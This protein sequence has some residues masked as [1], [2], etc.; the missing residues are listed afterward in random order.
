MMEVTESEE[1]ELKDLFALKSN[2]CSNFQRKFL[3][4]VL[5]EAIADSENL[6]SD[7]VLLV[8]NIFQLLDEHDTWNVFLNKVSVFVGNQLEKPAI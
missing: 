3:R 1:A 8:S 5:H 6:G 4:D 2:A 7:K